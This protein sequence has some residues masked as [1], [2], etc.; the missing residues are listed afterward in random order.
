M[1]IITF[2]MSFSVKDSNTKPNFTELAELISRELEVDASQVQ[3][4]FY[5]P[6]LIIS[7]DMII[8]SFRSVGSSRVQTVKLIL[9]HF[10]CSCILATSLT[11]KTLT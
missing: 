2:E 4:H 10:V 5:Y 1:G 8:S 3:S 6:A 11:Y 9:H 7:V